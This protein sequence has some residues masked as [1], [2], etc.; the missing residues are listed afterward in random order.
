MAMRAENGSVLMEFIIVLPLYFV[1]LGM[2]FLYGDLSL[3]AAN[4]AASGDRTLAVSHGMSPSEDPGWGKGEAM[5]YVAGA[6]S[7]SSNNEEVVSW[8]TDNAV[9]ISEKASRYGDKTHGIVADSGFKGSW[10][11]LVGSTLYDDYALAPITRTFVRAWN[12]QR[13]DHKERN[14]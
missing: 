8:Y 9:E 5:P 10:T 13:S 14:T 7:L 6:L 4:M 1:L 3:H 12:A 2:A 11:W